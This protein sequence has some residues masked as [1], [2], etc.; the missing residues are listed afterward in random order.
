M[1]RSPRESAQHHSSQGSPRST[2]QES[3]QSQAV[4]GQA[5]QPAEGSEEGED[6]EGGDGEADDLSGEPRLVEDQELP[7]VLDQD[8]AVHDHESVVD[9]PDSGFELELPPRQLS[10]EQQGPLPE[11]PG[12]RAQPRAPAERAECVSCRGR[13]RASTLR[14][15]G[16]LCANCAKI[17]A[18]V[19][20]TAEAHGGSFRLVVRG[21]GLVSLR[22]SC[23]RGHS[24]TLDFRSRP[25]KSWCRA[26]REEEHEE[27]LREQL[28]HQERLLEQQRLAQ[29]RLFREAR[30]QEGEEVSD[31]ES[32]HHQESPHVQHQLGLLRHVLLDQ[33][34]HP[35]AST[36]DP[37]LQHQV[38]EVIL[39]VESDVLEDFLR[40]VHDDDPG[41]SSASGPSAPS[42]SYRELVRRLRLSLHP[43]QNRSHSRA[44]EAF[45]RM[46]MFT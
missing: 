25:V 7:Q 9:P 16:R 15:G 41:P 2:C 28:A 30:E 10:H 24:W 21:P 12:P 4:S 14:L 5:G 26:C 31:V 37:Q 43:D 29:E 23:A 17:H 36:S 6:G 35:S 20:R 19:S 32:V 3:L 11:A 33:L 27:L 18:S 44:G 22:L 1:D 38:T 39:S 46:T 45:A 13:F 8:Q 40:R 34:L 42:A